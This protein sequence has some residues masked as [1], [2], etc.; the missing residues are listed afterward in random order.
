MMLTATGQD[1]YVSR[2]K[3][4]IGRNFG[5]KMWNA[6]RFMHDEQ[7]GGTL[8]GLGPGAGCCRQGGKCGRCA[9]PAAFPG[10]DRVRVTDNL[11]KYAVS[12]MPRRRLYEFVWHQFCDWYLE[13]AK[14]AFQGH[15]TGKAEQT[16]RIMHYCFAGACAC[17]IRSCLL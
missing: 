17:C 13:Y 7:R 14:T 4:E 3:F 16:K 1:V 12:M 10:G 11:E 9:H 6:A 5:T 2:E 8:W 15:D